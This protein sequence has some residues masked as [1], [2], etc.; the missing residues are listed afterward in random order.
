L[1][2]GEGP[3]A[4][5][6]WQRAVYVDTLEQQRTVYFD[7]LTPVGETH[8]STPVFESIRSLLFVV[9]ATH[10]KLGDSGRIWIKKAELQ[11]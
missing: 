4:G 9:D 3:S 7:D 2:G 1:R 8:A 11:R 5:D 10:A 6:R